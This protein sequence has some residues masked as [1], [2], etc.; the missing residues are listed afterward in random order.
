MTVC[1]DAVVRA[2]RF[3][4]RKRMLFTSQLALLCMQWDAV[5]EGYLMESPMHGRKRFGADVSIDL[6]M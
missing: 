1:S 4:R 5:E 2:Q 3:W 6:D